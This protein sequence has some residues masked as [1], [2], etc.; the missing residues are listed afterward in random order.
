M[1]RKARDRQRYR[2]HD[3]ALIEPSIAKAVGRPL[4]MPGSKYAGYEG[5]YVRPLTHRSA[6]NKKSYAQKSGRQDEGFEIIVAHISHASMKIYQPRPQSIHLNHDLA[7]TA[8]R[9]AH[10][11]L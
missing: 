1:R 8:H 2:D 9:T 3:I 6:S 4:S 11:N 10:F 7:A 5:K